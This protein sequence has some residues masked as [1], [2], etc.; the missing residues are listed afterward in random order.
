MLTDFFIQ[1]IKRGVV[2]RLNNL[3]IARVAREVARCVPAPKGAP[4]A[5][6]KASTGIDDLSWN[7]GFHLLASRALRLQGV[8]VVYFAC[9][10]GMSHCVLGTNR[11][12]PH[13]LP[14]CASCISQ[15]R[16][17]YT[18]VPAFERSK[19]QA[20]SS[21]VWWFPYREEPALA[22]A[23]EGATLQQLMEFQWQDVPLGALCLPG[24]RWILRRHNL[25]DDEGTRF[26]LREYILSAWNVAQEFTQFLDET[27]P[28]AVVVFNGQFYPEAVARYVAQQ[29]GL[30]VIT[31]EVGLQ[32]ASAF[33][34]EGEATAYPIHIPD[35]FELNAA[36]AARL[37]A[38]LEK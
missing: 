2:R 7:S 26:L 13:R 27:K 28:R 6:F 9:R 16:T 35:D 1:R 3:K 24:L 37:D 25:E 33:I 19:H 38:Y 23:L 29:R 12:D 36:Q 18:G 17:L 21:R 4:V 8:P 20:A 30:R 22:W 10:A 14:P 32:P 15:S 31:H 5:M 34:T 11:D